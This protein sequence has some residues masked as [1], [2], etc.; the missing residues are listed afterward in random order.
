MEGVEDMPK[1]SDYDRKAAVE[2]AH[3]WAYFRNP[4][5][6]NYQLLG[7]DCTNFASQCIYAGSKVMNYTPVFGWYYRS[8]NDKTPSW[9]GVR[10]LYNFLTSNKGLGPFGSEVDIKSAEPGDIVQLAVSSDNYHHTPVIV[11]VEG[12]PTLD[13]IFVAAHTNDCDCRPLSSYQGV[14]K[15]RFIHIEGVRK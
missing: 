5:F 6:Y 13:T 11:K 12:E 1:I 15:M 14:R 9:T 3:E 8:P 2:Y 10:F 4:A 7:G